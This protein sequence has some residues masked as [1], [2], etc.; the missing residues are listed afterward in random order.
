MISEKKYLKALKTVR[1][2]L[3]QIENE[4][5]EIPKKVENST[6]KEK[7]NMVVGDWVECIEVHGNSRDNLTKGNRYE[8]VRFDERHRDSY[9]YIIT[10]KGTKR[11]YNVKNTQFK[12]V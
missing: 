8:V 3:A 1:A 2:Y 5:S 12:A 9:F 6:K 11:E 4:I 10:D 7:R